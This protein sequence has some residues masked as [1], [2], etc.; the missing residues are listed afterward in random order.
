M[1]IA[2]THQPRGVRRFIAPLLSVLAIFALLLVGHVQPAAAATPTGTLATISNTKFV[3]T[4]TTTGNTAEITADWNFDP[5]TDPGPGAGFVIALPAELPG[6]GDTFPLTAA[7]DETVQIGTCVA[8]TSAL[9][10]VMDDAYVKANPKGLNGNVTF[11]VTITTTATTSTEHTYKVGNASITTTVNPRNPNCTEN[12]GFSWDYYKGGSYNYGKDTISWYVHIQSDEGGMPAGLNVRLV[13]SPDSY[14]TMTV[15]KGVSPLLQSTTQLGTDANS[16]KAI[17]TN[18]ALVNPNDY[19]VDPVTGELNFV[20][21]AGTY[22]Q[23]YYLTKAVSLPASGVYTNSIDYFIDGKSDGSS[24][25]EARYAGGSGSGIGTDFGAFSITKAVTGTA[26]GLP[27]DQAFTGTYVVTPPTGDSISGTYSVTAG[28]IWNSPSTFPRGSTVTLTETAPT[29][30]GNVT[31]STPQFS[32]NS[33]VLAG[34]TRTPVTLTNNADVKLGAFTAAK[35]ISGSAPARGLVPANTTF[36]FPYSYPAGVGFAAGS[37]TLTVGADGTPV[38]S[39]ELPVGAVVT[40]SEATPAAIPGAAWG[41]PK[42]SPTTV[43]I[44]DG[45]DATFA[46]VNPIAEVLGGFSV[47]KSVTG[48]GSALVADD[49][50]FAV[51]F[52]WTA[53]G[54]RSGL[55]TIQVGA[56]GTAVSVT[57]IPVGATVML[58]EPAP[59]AIDGVIW[60]TPVFSQHTFEITSNTLVDIT[61]TNPTELETGTFTAAKTITGTEAAQALVPEDTR[62]AIDFSYP[63]GAGF[64]AGSGTVTIGADG[65]GVT[66]EALPF[67]AEVTLS[68]QTAPAVAGAAWGTAI[69]TPQTFT[70]GAG[71]DVSVTVENPI[72]ETLGGFSLQKTVSGEAGSLVAEGTSFD[73]DYAWTTIDGDAGNGTV[74][75]VGGGDPVTVTGI[76]GGATVTLTEHAAATIEGVTWLDPIFSENGFTVIAGT[77]VAIDLDNPTQL[78]SGV[79]AVQKKLDGNGTALVP[80]NTEF[81]VEYSYPAGEGFEAGSGTLTV[82]ADGVVVT[83]DPLPFGA[84]VTLTE[85]TPENIAGATWTGA[86]FDNAEVT[87]GDGVVSSVVLTNSIDAVPPQKEVPPA[88]LAD[89]GFA[90]NPAPLFGAALALLLAGAAIS[91]ARRRQARA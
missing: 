12:C 41:T 21:K 89:T 91:I 65:T 6:R 32:K 27:A 38:R 74:T 44:G 15:E 84:K 81:A 46:V 77:T 39:P 35:T 60:Q 28:S 17:P 30:P 49:T 47:T 75:V 22:Y 80:A 20:T 7:D 87:V 4:A 82:K 52:T 66:S 40:L 23:A 88:P 76:P 69:I 79:I 90:G 71:T 55:G 86:A 2:P 51:D 61:L 34:G 48:A 78:S 8:G 85:A 50:T 13:D 18:W 70:V 14:Q 29:T 58:S 26:T 62:F 36:T 56:D 3:Q 68:E 63:A 73:V 67:G 16:G 11:W 83:S 33:F 5:D 43:T 45:A 9:E 24:T 59:T 64:D 72:A 53:S 54:A 19:T 31:W 37:G 1:S 57:D 10:C 42:I 25:A